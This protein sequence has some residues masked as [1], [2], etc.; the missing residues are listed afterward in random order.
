MQ[1]SNTG[2]STDSMYAGVLSTAT[3][4]AALATGW[5]LKTKQA[6]TSLDDPLIIQHR[7]HTMLVTSVFC[8]HS[9]QTTHTSLHYCFSFFTSVPLNL[10][11]YLVFTCLSDVEDYT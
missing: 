10:L 9:Y 5:K 8:A 7:M 11:L 6:G 4:V 2:I 1:K 3:A